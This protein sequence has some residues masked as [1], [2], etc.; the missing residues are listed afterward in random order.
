MSIAVYSSF[1][2]PTQKK[3][4]LS[5]DRKL[6][7]AQPHEVAYVGKKLGKGGK[8]AVLKAK[9]GLGRKTSRAAVTKKAKSLTKR[10]RA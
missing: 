4:S 9:K 5:R 1:A 3:K 6:V 8:A 7:S 10:S 2:M